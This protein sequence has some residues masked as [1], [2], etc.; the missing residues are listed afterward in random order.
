MPA[1]LGRFLGLDGHPLHLESAASLPVWPRRAVGLWGTPEQRRQQALQRKRRSDAAL[2][3]GGTWDLK[4][5]LRRHAAKRRHGGQ[6]VEALRQRYFLPDE[7]VAESS[8]GT[9][10]GPS[11]NQSVVWSAES[12]TWRTDALPEATRRRLL[13]LSD[14]EREALQRRSARRESARRAALRKERLNL[15]LLKTPRAPFPVDLEK[16][17]APVPSPAVC[18]E[19]RGH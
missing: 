7:G 4:S 17:A 5:A 3:L 10:P 19:R 15:N 16:H 6:A 1:W 13:V 12:R 14:L 18:E 8:W 9:D 11:V 2:A